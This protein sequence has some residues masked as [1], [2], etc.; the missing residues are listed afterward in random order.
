[1]PGRW[2]PPHLPGDERPDQRQRQ[3]DQCH[4][5]EQTRTALTLEE[6]DVVFGDVGTHG[7]GS[8]RGGRFEFGNE[9]RDHR[10]R[11]DAHFER[12]RAHECATE[13]AARKAWK[14]AALQR[15]QHA[16]G[17]LRGGGHLLQAQPSALARLFELFSEF[18]HD[19]W[20]KILL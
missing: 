9:L 19:G 17:N 1:L 6:R 8:R 2:T 20:L 5:Q 11:I 3:H 12:V 10:V 13:D 16:D 15:L 4:P 7:F 18:S 14:V